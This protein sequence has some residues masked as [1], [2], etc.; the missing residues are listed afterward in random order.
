[1]ATS[2]NIVAFSNET[3]LALIR[4]VRMGLAASDPS[5]FTESGRHLL[6]LVPGNSVTAPREISVM[7][8]YVKEAIGSDAAPFHFQTTKQF[9]VSAPNCVSH[10]VERKYLEAPH[11]LVADR[12]LCTTPEETLLRLSASNSLP[13]V[14]RFCNELSGCYSLPPAGDYGGMALTPAV[15]SPKLLQRSLGKWRSVPG[16]ARLE[17]AVR[18]MTPNAASP[19]EA[20]IAQTFALPKKMGG[21]FVPGLH[22]NYKV[23]GKASAASAP[24]VFFLDIYW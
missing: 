6:S 12:L 2:R 5:V 22:L 19:V 20:S 15:T 10:V 3:A 1:M 16:K 18:W 11:L 8:G 4:F 21:Y 9:Q 17:E 23:T 7:L 14:L 13:R 24:R